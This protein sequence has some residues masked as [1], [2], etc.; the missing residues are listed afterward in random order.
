[1]AAAAGLAFCHISHSGL[2]RP[3]TIVVLFGMAIT[4]FVNLGME[5]MAEDSVADRLGLVLEG[6]GGQSAV[7]GATV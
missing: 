4:A 7:A 6:L 1:M 3:L 5:I 2:A